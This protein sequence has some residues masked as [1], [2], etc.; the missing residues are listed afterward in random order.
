MGSVLSTSMGETMEKNQVKMMEQQRAMMLKQREVQMATQ[1]AMA[2]DNFKWF[3]AFYGIAGVGLLN[4]FRHTKKPA[5]IAPLVPL[6]FALA[7]QWDLARGAKFERVRAEADSILE[8]E[9][10]LFELPEHNRLISAS[11]YR[12]IFGLSK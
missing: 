4:G 3:A 2:R 7:F 8:K 12:S 11:E 9:A 1:L 5:F 10:Q 6:T